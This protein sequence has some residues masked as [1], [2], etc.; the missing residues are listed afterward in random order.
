MAFSLGF[1]ALTILTL[2]FDFL[3]KQWRRK[4]LKNPREKYLYSLLRQVNVGAAP[5]G[6]QL[7]EQFYKKVLIS[8]SHFVTGSYYLEEEK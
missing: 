2:T 7:I 1:K 3:Q 6:P 4:S 8:V 5:S